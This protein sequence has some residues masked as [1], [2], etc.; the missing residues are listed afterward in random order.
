MGQFAKLVRVYLTNQIQVAIAHVLVYR[1]MTISIPISG[2]P[3]ERTLTN[4]P[5]TA[6]IK[7]LAQ[8]T[9]PFMKL[10]PVSRAQ[11]DEIA[12]LK[13]ISFPRLANAIHATL[14]KLL[15]WPTVANVG[16][17]NFGSFPALMVI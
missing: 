3:R 16:Y 13:L 2:Y 5:S 10:S 1:S 12:S 9:G 17:L 6:S 11:A 4:P 15:P 8:K 7:P 14:A